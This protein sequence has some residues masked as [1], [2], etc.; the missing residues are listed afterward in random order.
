MLSPDFLADGRS[1][2]GLR[3][4]GPA[5][6]PRAR[7]RGAHERPGGVVHG[8][9]RGRGGNPM[10]LGD[11]GDVARRHAARASRR[12]A[13][14]GSCARSRS[15]V[16]GDDVFCVVQHG[17][18]GVAA[19]I[20]DGP[21]PCGCG[22][23]RPTSSSCGPA[24]CSGCRRPTPPA[25]SPSTSPTAA[26]S[27]SS[28]GRASRRG[29]GRSGPASCSRSS[30]WDSP[31]LC[32]R[33]SPRAGSRGSSWPGVPSR[34]RQV[35]R[36]RRDGTRGAGP[37]RARAP[38]CGRRCSSG[39]SRG[40]SSALPEILRFAGLTFEHARVGVR[41]D[42]GSRRLFDLAR[43]EAG[44]PA[45]RALEG[46]ALDDAGEP[47]SASLLAALRAVVSS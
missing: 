46:I 41:L 44:P 3:P 24:A 11:S 2:A 30:G 31:R 47:T 9:A 16:D 1:P 26:A 39:T 20:V 28:S 32:R 45:S 10:P 12:R 15:H 14:R 27:R 38:G 25:G 8:V 42:D 33:R 21:A 37:L 40:D 34:H 43:P 19:D 7:D 17:A 22:R 18:R 6:R 36:P 4:R 29:S 23:C 13:A 35:G 5:A